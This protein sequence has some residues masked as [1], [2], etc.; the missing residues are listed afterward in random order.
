MVIAQSSDNQV[1]WIKDFDDNKLIHLGKSFNQVWGHAKYDFLNDPTFFIKSVSDHDQLYLNCIMAKR[2][3]LEGG[4]LQYLY[5][6]FSSEGKQQWFLDSCYQLNSGNRILGYAGLTINITSNRE[7]LLNALKLFR[8]P[9]I[10]DNTLNIET[11]LSKKELECLYYYVRG[12]TA[13]SIS[14]Y[15]KRSPKTIESHVEHIKEKLHT[16]NRAELLNVTWQTD[17]IYLYL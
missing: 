12:Y 4:H 17:L 15:L 7:R 14:N 9:C 11:A 1:S 2:K 8:Q 16:Q 6:G 3:Q 5:R 13:K 10:T